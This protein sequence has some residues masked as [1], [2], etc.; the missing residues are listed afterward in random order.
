MR[1]VFVF[2]LKPINNK[3][4]YAL[5][6]DL[7]AEAE[8]RLVKSIQSFGDGELKERAMKAHKSS[9]KRYSITKV[10]FRDP[11]VAEYAKR[12]ANGICD[13]CEKSAPFI[14]KNNQPYL[15][16][17][18][19]V[20]LS[21]GGEDSIE[22]TVALCPNCHRKMHVLDLKKDIEKLRCRIKN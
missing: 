20:W 4:N 18:H 17:H 19:I 5:P 11:Y 14:N 1:T 8:K 9:K 12:R 13:L 21:N 15:E 3:S 2:P 7:L 10:Y 16:T 6:N 22:N